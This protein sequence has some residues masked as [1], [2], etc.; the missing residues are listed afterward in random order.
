VLADPAGGVIV[1]WEPGLRRG[2]QLVNEAGAWSMSR[3]GASDPEA[4]AAF[5]GA[6][7]GWRRSPSRWARTP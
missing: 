1:A 4:A 6:V 3:L 7:F 2:A 5:Y